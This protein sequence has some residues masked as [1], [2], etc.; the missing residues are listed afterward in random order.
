MKKKIYLYY[1]NDINDV[2][3]LNKGCIKELL[4]FGCYYAYKN[5]DKSS[6]IF[7]IMLILKICL[8]ILFIIFLPIFI[9]ILLFI[10]FNFLINFL[11]SYNYNDIILNDYIKNG[12][13][14][15]DKDSADYLLEKGIYFKLV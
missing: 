8:F 15:L 1:E 3:E 10:I 12:Y 9:S 5:K 7:Y 6:K 13:V 11:F 2:V 4:Y 14:P